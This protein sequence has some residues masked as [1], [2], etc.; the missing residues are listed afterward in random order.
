VLFSGLFIQSFSE[1]HRLEPIVRSG[2][3]AMVP[4]GVLD[5]TLNRKPGHLYLAEAHAFG[6][7]SGSP[8][9]IDTNKFAN[10]IGGPSYKFLGVISGEVL[11]N[12]DL[13]LNVTT[14]FAANIG[15]NSDVSTVVPAR[16]LLKILNGK[17][18]Q[19]ERDAIIAKQSG[20]SQ[21]TPKSTTN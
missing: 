8:M 7:N 18:L 16:E 10:I 9:F 17:E 19:N 14:S 2:T 5:T 15:A 4:E 3:L 13:T 20:S 11:E 12:A 6:G 1:V 21:G